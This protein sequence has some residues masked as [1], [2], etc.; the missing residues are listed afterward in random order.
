MN[1]PEIVRKNRE[2]NIPKR[3][4]AIGI[5]FFYA[6]WSSAAAQ[7]YSFNEIVP[8]VRQPASVSGGSACPIPSRQLIAANSIAVQWST[9]LGTSPQTIL[10]TNQTSPGNLNE[11]QAVIQQAES[12]WSG[13]AAT[14]LAP[15]TF[16]PLTQVA[17]AN[18]CGADGINSICFDQP[19][20]GF[21]PGVLAF[22]R[23]ITADALNIQL[24]SVISTQVGQILDADIYFNPSDPSVTF[25]TPS[26]LSAN[27]GA[28]DMESLMI[29]EFGHL[30]GFGHS[31]VF[32]AIMF[33]FAAAPGTFSGQR[34]TAQQPDAPLGDD[35]RAGLRTLYTDPTDTAYTGSIQGQ[36]L[37]ANPLSLP[38]TPSGVTGIFGAHVVA[39]NV[40]TGNV[41]AATLGGWSCSAPGPAQFDGTY[42]IQHLPVGNSYSV[43]VEPLN[44]VVQPA[45]VS[46][47]L[48]TLCRNENTDPGW[49]PA[50][51]CVAP[52]ADQEFTT[53]TLPAP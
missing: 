39:V 51:A 26:A 5:T 46:T 28:Y 35:D 42:L 9:V 18:I 50:Q 14:E 52:A 32:S 43:Y 13:V 12:V 49:P 37:P 3:I 33:P 38:S 8:D 44:G 36:I 2:G 29:H 10:T 30:L 47:T 24:G 45:N 1:Q 53:A 40:A 41:M 21:T 31:A 34:P 25:A 27:P 19:D 20:M 16:A 22:T 7:G 15:S 4:R 17:T 11:I 6:L 23:V 48:A